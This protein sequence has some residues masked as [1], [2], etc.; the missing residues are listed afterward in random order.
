[1]GGSHSGGRRAELDS[2]LDSYISSVRKRKPFSI[3]SKRRSWSIWPFS[4]PDNSLLSSAKQT[5]AINARRRQPSE[6]E[7]RTS[8]WEGIK[9]SMRDTVRK[10]LEKINQQ[11]QGVSQMRQD[12][13]FIDF[14]DGGLKVVPIPDD[15]PAMKTKP[16]ITAMNPSNDINLRARTPQSITQATEAAPVMLDPF[17]EPAAEEKP[18]KK[19]GFFSRLFSRN[20]AVQEES[21]M[22]DEFL[23]HAAAVPSIAPDPELKDDFKELSKLF[24]K[25]LERMSKEQ[26]N[27][28]KSTDDFERFKTLLKKHSVIK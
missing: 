17:A 9:T 3:G 21:K 8:F 20:K 13:D 10:D 25:S 5:L 28:F 2:E 14:E 6:E 24:L 19:I 26:L 7:A 16:A 12:D 15:E 4:R 1:M 23:A 27:S 18:A 11:Q 22:D